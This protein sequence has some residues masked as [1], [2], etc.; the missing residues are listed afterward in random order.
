MGENRLDFH[1]DR[2]TVFLYLTLAV[3][4]FKQAVLGSVLP[5]MRD[6][7]A[8]TTEAIGWHFTVYALGLVLAA[9]ITKELGRFVHTGQ[10]LIIASCAMVTAIPLI[11]LTSTIVASLVIALTL[12][13]AGGTTQIAIQSLLV[14][15]HGKNQGIALVEAFV[16]AAF[17]VFTA[18]L[19]IGFFAGTALG[20][21]AALLIPVLALSTI[22]IV[23]RQSLSTHLASSIE[24]EGPLPTVDGKLPLFI[25][26]SLGMILLGIATEW[27][28][29]FWGAQFIEAQ[30]AIEPETAVTMMSS[31]FGGTFIGRILVSQL[32]RKMPVKTVLTALILSGSAAVFTM[33]FSSDVNLVWVTLFISGACLGNFFPLIL[34]LANELLPGRSTEISR[35]ATLA[36]GIALLTVPYLI[37]KSGALIGL[38]TVVGL[39]AALPVGMLA[40]LFWLV[41]LHR[42]HD[43]SLTV[44]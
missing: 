14:N 5:F 29:G 7:M 23:F 8:L 15:H 21:R 9:R 3:F 34:S 24:S 36:V 31:F 25:V 40:L 43:T 28:I 32:L 11:S 1:R 19:T 26:L 37:G 35:G 13:A 17:G 27:G 22:F 30:L 38:T 6:E 44:D 10:I 33:T 39:L 4:G 12:G 41:R 42:E 18:P 20:W 16:M 2:Y